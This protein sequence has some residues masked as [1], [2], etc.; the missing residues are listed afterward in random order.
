MLIEKRG[1]E[2]R[3]YAV[4]MKSFVLKGVKDTR[5]KAFRRRIVRQ[6][7]DNVEC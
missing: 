3:I 5:R 4:M 6:V 7:P 2:R 1:I